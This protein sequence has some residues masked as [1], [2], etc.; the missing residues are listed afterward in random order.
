MLSL[1]KQGNVR[2][3]YPTLGRTKVLVIID[4]FVEC[5]TRDCE[6][7]VASFLLDFFL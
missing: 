4:Y 1:V 7:F 5:A 3:F 6:A 2:P